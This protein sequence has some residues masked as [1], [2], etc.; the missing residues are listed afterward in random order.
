VSRVTSAAI[1]FLAVADFERFDHAVIVDEDL[2]IELAQSLSA[3]F[4]KRAL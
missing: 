3:D 2:P 1:H 4:E